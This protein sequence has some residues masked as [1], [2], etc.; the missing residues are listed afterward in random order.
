M[1]ATARSSVTGEV[2]NN[3]D[4]DAVLSLLM[5]VMSSDYTMRGPAEAHI[6]AFIGSEGWLEKMLAA[7]FSPGASAMV[8]QLAM[9]LIKTR[10][11]KEGLCVAF[12]C[13]ACVFG[14]GGGW[15]VC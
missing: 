13:L 15:R 6:R 12:S 8:S 7:V 14:E 9:I 3:H 11:L 2:V 5:A 4:H 10:A 1:D